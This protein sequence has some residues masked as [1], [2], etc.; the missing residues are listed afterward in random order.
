MD[1]QAIGLIGGSFALVVG[2]LFAF[3]WLIAGDPERES[4][5]RFALAWIGVGGA[6]LSFIS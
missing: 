6:V 3:C 5:G 4:Y 1:K 2:V